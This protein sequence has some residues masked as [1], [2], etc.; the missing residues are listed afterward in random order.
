MEF[1][2]DVSSETMKYEIGAKFG[3][4]RKNGEVE[5]KERAEQFF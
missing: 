4:F 3:F 2:W 1:F 5:K